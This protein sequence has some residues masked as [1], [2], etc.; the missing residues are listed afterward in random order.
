MWRTCFQWAPHQLFSHSCSCTYTGQVV[1]ERSEDHLRWRAP[2]FSPLLCYFL[3]QKVVDFLYISA[4]L[5]SMSWGSL[6][7]GKKACFP[8]L[9]LCT[10]PH[11]A[12]RPFRK[13]SKM[14]VMMDTKPTVILLG[15]FAAIAKIHHGGCQ[16]NITLKVFLEPFFPSNDCWKHPLLKFLS[17]LGCLWKAVNLQ[18]FSI[19][20]QGLLEEGNLYT[21]GINA[22]V[23][24][25]K[26]PTHTHQKKTKKLEHVSLYCISSE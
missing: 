1:E 26:M 3:R 8:V 9:G 21:C 2:L 14:A 5:S 10:G 6:R 7:L 22:V 24:T 17:E 16:W 13:E 4:V 12:E 15:M 23:I 18:V 25:I 11:G 19:I 20:F